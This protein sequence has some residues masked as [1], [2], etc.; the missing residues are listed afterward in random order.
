MNTPAVCQEAL[1]DDELTMRGDRYW[2]LSVN[3]RA[4]EVLNAQVIKLSF[5]RAMH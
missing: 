2:Q 1:S 5:Y 4:A 3:Q